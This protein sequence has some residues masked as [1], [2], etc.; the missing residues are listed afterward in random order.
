MSAI[1]T[2]GQCFETANNLAV[3][4]LSRGMDP[5]VVHA[6]VT[7]PNE[8]FRHI[9]AWVEVEG[10]VFDYEVKEGFVISRDRYYRAGQIRGDE[11]AYYTLYEALE[12]MFTHDHHG[13][14]DRNLLLKESVPE[15]FEIDCNRPSVG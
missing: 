7:H 1:K 2:G 15:E 12:N 4:F 6:L 5:T 9:H 10:L 3:T 14:W 11:I 8:G 13:P